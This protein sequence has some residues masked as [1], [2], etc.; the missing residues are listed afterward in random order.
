MRVAFIFLLFCSLFKASLAQDLEINFHGKVVS[1]SSPLYNVSVVNLSQNT[2]TVTD[3]YGDFKLSVKRGDEISFSSI[4]YKSIVYKVPSD[5]QEVD[6]RVLVNLVED[7]VY[8]KEAVVVPWPL[9]RT[10]LKEAMLDQRKEKEQIS[11]YAGFIELEGDPEPVSPS[12]MNPLSF[13]YSKFNKKARQEKKMEKYRKILQ[14][15]EFYVP[16]NVY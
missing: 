15:D 6:F 1:G 14:E 16:E 2:G 13:I 5:I 8:L 11:P 10:M 4:A 7:T 9:N 12:L 3:V